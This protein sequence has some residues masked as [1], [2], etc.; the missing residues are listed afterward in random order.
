MLH[1]KTT[2]FVFLA[3]QMMARKSLD[4][5]YDVTLIYPDVVPQTEKILLQGHFPK[6]V[7]VHFAR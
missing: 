2:G 4:S 1:P 7:K 5:I 6:Q 3:S